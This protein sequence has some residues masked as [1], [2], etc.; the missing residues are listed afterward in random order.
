MRSQTTPTPP[1]ARRIPARRICH[2][3]TFVDE[4]AWLADKDRPEV[5]GYLRAENTYAAVMTEAQ[6]TL[7]TSIFDE[8]KIRTK[9]TDVSA[10]VRKGHWW[11][12]TRTAESRQYPVCCRCPALPGEALPP[13]PQ[14][15]DAGEARARAARPGW[16]AL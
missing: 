2:G 14:D 7:R 13:A 15:A 12:Y 3:D 11:Y 16:H 4:F 9:E 6:A 10:P 8:I 5:A 1:A